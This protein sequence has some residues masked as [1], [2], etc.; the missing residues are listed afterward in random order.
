MS[1]RAQILSR[2]KREREIRG[3]HAV[4]GGGGAQWDNFNIF[5]H[6][7]KKIQIHEI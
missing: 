3:M 6:L 2:R 7:R 5:V 4:V 1:R